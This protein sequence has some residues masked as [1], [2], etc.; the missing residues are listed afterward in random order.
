[1]IGIVVVSHGKIGLEM[2]RVARSIVHDPAPMAG[3]ALE[4]DESVDR[5]RDKISKAIGEVNKNGGILILSDMFGG[6]PSNLCLSF[7]EEGKI[8]VIT[9]VNLPM[10]IKLAN[11]RDDKPL[12]EIASFI[13]NYGQK[14]IALAGEV[15]K[16]TEGSKP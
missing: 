6:T 11:F 7:L 13:R 5:M 15:L 10:L 16:G 8:E 1:M 2:V 14:N 9:G 4:H 3:V 12:S